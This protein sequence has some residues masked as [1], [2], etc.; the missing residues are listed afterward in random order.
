VKN[1]NVNSLG[2]RGWLITLCSFL[3]F[4]LGTGVVADFLNI[5]VPAISHKNGWNPA[6]LLTFSTMGGWITLVTS[7]LIGNLIRKI[8]PRKVMGVSILLFS[9]CTFVLGSLNSIALYGAIVLMLSVLDAAQSGMAMQTV[10]SSWFPRKKGIVMGWATIGLSLSTVAFLPFFAWLNGRFGIGGA[11]RVVGIIS[12]V[13]GIVCFLVVRDIPEEC[14]L[15]PDNDSEESREELEKESAKIQAYIKSSPFTFGKIF[16]TKQVWQISIMLGIG[17]MTATGVLSQFVA[18]MASMGV[19]I[20]VA[21]SILSLSGIIAMPFSYLWGFLDS[22]I[23]PKK[24]STIQLVWYT[25]ALI[26]MV[27]VGKNIVGNYVGV[28]MFFVALGGINNMLTSYTASVFGRY[29]FASAN[30]LIYPI[31]SAV[32]CSAFAI[33]GIGVSL[34]GSYNEVY[35]LFAAFCAIGVIISLFTKDTCIGRTDAD[36]IK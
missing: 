22:K 2:K 1:T 10:I 23:G 25:V 3:L 26:L 21:V 7:F 13:I 34:F 36:M 17:M 18:R 9:I 32:R 24:V 27:M 20:G 33:V 5:S 8:G 11:Y 28:F 12:L 19:G 29:D 4:M 31:Y 16:R 15:A 30:R 14:G 6:I 35:L